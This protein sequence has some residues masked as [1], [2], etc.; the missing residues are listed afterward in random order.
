MEN[1]DTH[2]WQK[3]RE[4]LN[5]IDYSLVDCAAVA[6]TKSV[7]IPYVLFIHLHKKERKT[8]RVSCC[9]WKCQGKAALGHKQQAV[10]VISSSAARTRRSIQHLLSNL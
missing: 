5:K 7:S 3:W 6:M 4:S 8:K 10:W 9:G 2:I 1:L